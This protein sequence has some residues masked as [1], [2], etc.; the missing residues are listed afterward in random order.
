MWMDLTCPVCVYFMHVL[1]FVQIIHI[2]LSFLLF[3]VTAVIKS[4][5]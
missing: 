1:H 2:K 5:E 4:T 3:N